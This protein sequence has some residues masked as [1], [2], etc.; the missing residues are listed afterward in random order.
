MFLSSADVQYCF[1]IVSQ[2]CGNK[3]FFHTT[4]PDLYFI[5]AVRVVRNALYA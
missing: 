2:F 5:L 3:A 4:P 1:N